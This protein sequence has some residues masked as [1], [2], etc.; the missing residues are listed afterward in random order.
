MHNDNEQYEHDDEQNDLADLF[1]EDGWLMRRTEDGE[2]VRCGTSI[3][4]TAVHNN[5]DNDDVTPVLSFEYRGI[6]RKITVTRRTLSPNGLQ[7]LV[8]K[9]ADT[10]LDVAKYYSTHLRNQERKAPVSNVHSHL[11]WGKVHDTLVFK[12]AKTIGDVQSKYAGTQYNIT[13]AGTFKAWRALMK[14][15]VFGN[16]WLELALSVGLSSAL[17]GLLSKRT[18]IDSLLFHLFGRSSTGKT[19]ATR[20][21]VS[22]WGFPDKSGNGLI[23]SWDGSEV[24]ILSNFRNNFGITVALDEASVKGEAFHGLVYK[25][26]MGR[27]RARLN[28]DATQQETAEW[29][30]TILSNGEHS[31]LDGSNMNLG[32]RVRLIEASPAQWTTSRENADTLTE[33]LLVNYGHAGPRLVRTLMELGEEAIFARW[34]TWSEQMRE[35]MPVR[36]PLAERVARKLGLIL[37]T[38]DVAT[39]RLGLG[40]DLD[41]LQQTLLTIEAEAATHRAEWQNAYRILKEMVAQNE[42]KFLQPTDT[43]AGRK[44]PAQV[45]GK[46][47]PTKGKG[48]QFYFLC[49]AFGEQMRK[50]GFT[51][52]TPILADW[53]R[54]GILLGEKD[55]YTTDRTIGSAKRCEVYHIQLDIDVRALEDDAVAV[56]EE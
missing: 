40:F 17:V 47:A 16:P 55:R 2:T 35:Q 27:D 22:P 4:V 45:W 13:P 49:D 11:G 53:R 18:Y 9:G 29:A 26:A 30:T 36:D 20:L 23:R 34:Q 33:G 54:M 1:D 8:D 5:I 32:I 25:L 12:H 7:E 51:N 56:T 21:A 39:E 44:S 50:R 15:E 52:V 48:V 46:F 42:A 14:S 24:S 43:G 38:A 10:Y 19:T 3:F 28:R 31:L 41:G 37:L 6:T